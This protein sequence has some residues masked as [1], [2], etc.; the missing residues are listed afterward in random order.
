[1]PL[2]EYGAQHDLK[3]VEITGS[4]PYSADPDGDDTDESGLSVNPSAGFRRRPM[5]ALQITDG[6]GLRPGA[7]RRHQRLFLPLA[8]P[9]VDG[10]GNQE[11]CSPATSCPDD[12]MHTAGSTQAARS[13]Q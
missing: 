11:Y 9:D 13:L 12:C 2:I 5:Y 8:L 6:Y 4:L 7:D 1:M 10:D 3:A